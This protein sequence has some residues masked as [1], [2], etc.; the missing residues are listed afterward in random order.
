MFKG[1]KQD[2]SQVVKNL[3]RGLLSVRNETQASDITSNILPILQAETKTVIDAMKAG[4][5]RKHSQILASVAFARALVLAYKSA[6]DDE[7]D[8]L[9]EVIVQTFATAMTCTG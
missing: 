5:L 8:A 7:K 3:A 9:S 1:Q 4:N 2:V 6:K